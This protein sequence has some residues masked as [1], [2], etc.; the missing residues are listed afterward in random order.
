[1]HSSKS[2]SDK[3]SKTMDDKFDAVDQVLNKIALD[4]RL[5]IEAEHFKRIKT[6][7]LLRFYVVKKDNNIKL[8]IRV[9]NYYS[10]ELK[11]DTMDLWELV[12]RI[13]I[14]R[15]DE[16][17]E[18]DEE[19]EAY[20]FQAKMKE[21]TNI[22]I[23]VK[24]T[25]PLN[26]MKL[27]KKL[28]DFLDLYA[29]SIP[30]IIKSLYKYIIENELINQT[31]SIV[32]CDD[33][34]KEVFGV[35]AFNFNKM[36]EMVKDHVEPIDY[37]KIE[38]ENDDLIKLYDTEVECDD[39]TQMPILYTADVK[40]INKK[41]EGNKMLER[42]ISNTIDVLE[43]FMRNPIQMISRYLI[44]EKDIMGIKTKYFEDLNI[45]NILFE[46]LMTRDD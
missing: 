41:I 42:R 7:K 30:N 32:T 5:Q 23:Y 26:W 14:V 36:D 17:Y 21:P 16:I 31:T 38:V 22:K 12:K 8:F 46:L 20:A 28:S 29:N 15:D 9:M 39:I 10:G 34:L 13:I 11:M 4:K 43:E 24:F 44:L 37:L 6:S 1:M 33:A 27:D 19:S 2:S 45:Q 25:N 3:F 35:E 18:W 40:M